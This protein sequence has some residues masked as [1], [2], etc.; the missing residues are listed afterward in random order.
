MMVEENLQ[1]T[2]KEPKLER[3]E[4]GFGGSN[5]LRPTPPNPPGDG[6]SSPTNTNKD[7]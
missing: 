1:K 6:T 3:I 5:N 7:R 2:V 4:K